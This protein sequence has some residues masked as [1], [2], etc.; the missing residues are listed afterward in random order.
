M[1][2]KFNLPFPFEFVDFDSIQSNPIYFDSA[3]VMPCLH[4]MLSL[5]M[6]F[7]MMPLLITMLRKAMPPK[8]MPQ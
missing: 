4:T 5:E 7:Y 1:E 8:V 3:I 2:C 6:P